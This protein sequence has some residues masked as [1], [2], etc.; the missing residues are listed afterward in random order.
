MD[1]AGIS[2]AL[3]QMKVQNNV[4][5][6]MLSKTMDTNETMGEGIVS[7]IDKTGRAEMERSVN[8]MVGGN[9]DYYA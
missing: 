1:I 4:G 2:M 5:T 3:S 6:A 9:I 8:P 7:M